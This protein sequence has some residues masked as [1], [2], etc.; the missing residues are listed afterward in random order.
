MAAWWRD[1]LWPLAG[2]GTVAAL[3][4]LDVIRRRRYRRRELAKRIR[5]A[6]ISGPYRR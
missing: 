5:A 1:Y 6:R 2:V 4:T 3:F